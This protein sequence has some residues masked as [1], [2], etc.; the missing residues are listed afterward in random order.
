M[1]LFLRLK[2]WQIFGLLFGLPMVLQFVA[3]S[4][5]VN[6][7][8]P[9]TI[10]IIPFMTLLLMVLFCSWL[11]TLG[12]SL[13]KKLPSDIPMHLIKFKICGSI[14]IL[15]MV[16]IVFFGIFHFFL[17]QSGDST[18]II[19]MGII[20]P[21]HLLS[22]FCLFYCI[23]FIA[24]ALRSVELN[25]LVTFSDFAGDFFLIWFFPIGI[26]IIQPRINR[27]FIN[28]HDENSK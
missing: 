6:T 1:N 21:M 14:P 28:H 4:M 27:L 17:S 22:M 8:S 15:Y 7:L 3:I 19:A 11:Y 26:W 23:Y 24:K 18:G 13:H 25:R 20:M 9:A 10:I 12:I 2:A 16:F 5:L